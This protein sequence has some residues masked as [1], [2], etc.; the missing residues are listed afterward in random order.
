M[1]GRSSRSELRIED[2]DVS[3]RHALLRY[4]GKVWEV[5]DL[6]SRNGTFVDGLKLRPT[7]DHVLKVGATLRFGE[8]EDE[9][10]FVDDAPPVVMAVAADSSR[11]VKADGSVLAVPSAEEPEVT[12][13]RGASGQWFIETAD[14][15]VAVVADHD[16]FE[17]AGKTW[18]FCCPTVIARTQSLNQ[19]LELRGA[20]LRFGVSPDEEHVELSARCSGREV[21]LGSR[22]HNY[23][24]LVLARRRLA[25][26]ERGFPENTAGWMYQDDV[27][28]DLGIAQP[29]LNIDV[30]RIRR[31]FATA[32]FVDA[33][34]AI[35]RR[36]ST[37]QLRIGVVRLRIETV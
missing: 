17:A 22:A 20:E 13:Y 3:S 25:E 23:L 34:S 29:Q 15:P 1:V 28:R 36:S 4:N 6:G 5:R 18:R 9:W 27:V 19:S 24:L 35:E 14:A 8:S 37:R 33:A 11:A 12:L 10:T 30:F 2:S 26:T 31:H 16:T 32:G 21:D 7:E